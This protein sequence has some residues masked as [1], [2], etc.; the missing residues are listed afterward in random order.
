MSGK[1]MRQP[2]VGVK[3]IYQE[4]RR[5]LAAFQRLEETDGI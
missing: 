1:W 2:R 5:F 3:W 4:K